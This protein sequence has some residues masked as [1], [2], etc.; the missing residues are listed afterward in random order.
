MRH[1]PFS[2]EDKIVPAE[3]IRKIVEGSYE[4]L[5]YRLDEAVEENRSLFT[6]RNI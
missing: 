4:Q 1:N 5:T 6:S 3:A 2:I